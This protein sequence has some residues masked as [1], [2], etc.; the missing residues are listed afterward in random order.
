MTGETSR[1]IKT[2]LLNLEMLG[3][4]REQEMCVHHLSQAAAC[5]ILMPRVLSLGPNSFEKGG[6]G[7]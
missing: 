2:A 4:P 5:P 7:S 1:G 3:Y 6:R